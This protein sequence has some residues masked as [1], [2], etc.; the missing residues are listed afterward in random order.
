MGRKSRSAA[1]PLDTFDYWLMP[2]GLRGFLT[3]VF[4]SAA[5]ARGATGRARDERA[6]RVD[7]GPAGSRRRY[8]GPRPAFPILAPGKA[9]GAAPAKGK[10]AVGEH[11]FWRGSLWGRTVALQGD[12]SFTKFD[13]FEVSG[14]QLLYWG[15]FR[16]NG[17]YD[18]EETH[19]FSS[20]FPWM[21]Q[22]MR[23]G[24]VKQQRVTDSVFDPR[25]RRAVNSGDGSLRVE[26][27]AHHD[28]WRDPDSQ[29]VY[30]DV[31]EVHYWGR[32][33]EA[34]SREVYHLGRGLGTIRFETFNRQEPSGV[35]YQYAEYFERFTPPPLPALPWVD[36]FHNATHVRNGYFEDFLIPP[37]E[38]GAVA[39]SL[40]GWSGS[41]NAAITT[42]GGD[43]GT[44]PW[45]IVLRGSR[46][47]GDGSADFVIPSEWIPVTPGQRYR[48][49]GRL[50]RRSARD[51]AYLD[52][53]DGVGQGGDFEDAQAL[54]ASTGAWETVEAET[55]V[56]TG[57]TG[58]RVRFVRDGAD[59]SDAYADAITLQRL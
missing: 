51:N 29:T 48:L 16:G 4:W 12:S 22:W 21:D 45:K 55:S 31:L 30:E 15:T 19:S 1:E 46:S 5:A 25:L 33:P 43:E 2:H 53:G 52:F 13:L 57:T 23:V 14:P 44:S 3:T 17:Y 41:R 10:R 9:A 50:W 39:S 24:D 20:P 37:V 18:S 28:T 26:I 35:R 38:G 59:E 54:A 7:V 32:Y 11:A 27:V 8:P 42:A 49:S 6:G 34:S 47:G 40:R 56:G 36:P 58:V